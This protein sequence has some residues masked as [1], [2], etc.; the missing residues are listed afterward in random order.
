MAFRNENT[1]ICPH[2]ETGQLQPGA[3][4]SGFRCD[5]CGNAVNGAFM[6]TLI[7]ILSL[8]DAL[9]RHACECGHPEMR[10]LPGGVFCCPSC[11]AEVVPHDIRR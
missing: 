10:L 11:R 2:C 6:S 7:R 8:P 9:G 1:L 5:G 4:H 3:L